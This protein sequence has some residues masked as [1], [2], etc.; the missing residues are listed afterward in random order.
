MK[1][2]LIYKGEH[3]FSNKGVHVLDE[4]GFA[5]LADMDLECE[6]EDDHYDRVSLLL[7]ESRNL[8]LQEESKFKPQTE[9]AEQTSESSLLEE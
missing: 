7:E 3:L 2:I 9:Q 8:K 6:V 1:K 4:R 5:K